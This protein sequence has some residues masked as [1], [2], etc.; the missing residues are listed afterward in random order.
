MKY[1]V[2]KVGYSLLSI[3]A[4]EETGNHGYK[5]KSFWVQFVFN[6]HSLDF[7]FYKCNLSAVLF[8]MSSIE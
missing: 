5:S 4:Y 8:C 7:F 3:E 1:F 6:T 2:L